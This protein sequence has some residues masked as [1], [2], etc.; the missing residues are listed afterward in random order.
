MFSDSSYQGYWDKGRSTRGY[1]TYYMR[2]VV[3]HSSNL[4]DP[5]APSSAES[6]YNEACLAYQ[7]NSHIHA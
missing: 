7:E 2:G 5:V 6:E 3:Y 4:P 1:R